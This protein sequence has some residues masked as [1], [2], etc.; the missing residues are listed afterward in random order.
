LANSYKRVEDE[1]RSLV[2]EPEVLAII[3]RE[4][5][6]KGTDALNSKQINNV[7]RAARQNKTKR[8]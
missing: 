8:R 6:T 4:S 2:I 3:G 7:I 5:K 1:Q